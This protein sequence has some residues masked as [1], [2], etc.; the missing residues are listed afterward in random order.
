MIKTRLLPLLFVFIAFAACKKSSTSSGPGF[1]A[2]INGNS[3]SATT[4]A[5]VIQTNISTGA[6]AISITG[7]STS[8]GSIK[9]INLHLENYTG[10]TGTLA[11]TNSGDYEATYG[12]GSQVN[13]ATSGSV[14]I[15]NTTG[16]VSGT[17]SFV[18]D[19]MNVTSG[20]FTDVPVH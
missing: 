5:A 3:W 2:T 10:T 20:S 14:S 19:S 15:T 6:H 8:P 1:T 4:Y 7:A 16:G 13:Y 12:S 17:F 18:A 11:I 9:S